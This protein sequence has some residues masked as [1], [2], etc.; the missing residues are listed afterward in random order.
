M[1]NLTLQSS[2]QEWLELHLAAE[3]HVAGAVDQVD[4][5]A[6]RR[7]FADGRGRGRAPAA[8]ALA[9]QVQQRDGAGLHGDA[10]GLPGKQMGVVQLSAR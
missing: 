8:A 7:S 1:D 4:Q 5:D 9:H 3:V 6:V 2:H 10:A